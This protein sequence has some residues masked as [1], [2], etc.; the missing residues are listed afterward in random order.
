[1]GNNFQGENIEEQSAPQ[2]AA[3]TASQELI[4]LW[5]Q[6][7]PNSDC[8]SFI[9]DSKWGQNLP[10]EPVLADPEDS[11]EET[12]SDEDFSW[13]DFDSGSDNSKS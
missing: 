3:S 13:T 6:F 7:K 2:T 11:A 8:G 9:C 4:S 10:T 5:E 1:M 12:E